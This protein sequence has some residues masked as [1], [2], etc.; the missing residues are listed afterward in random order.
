MHRGYIVEM[1]VSTKASSSTSELLGGRKKKEVL[2]SRPV[3]LRMFAR[4]SSTSGDL[5]MDP[6]LSNATTSFVLYPDLLNMLLILLMS[7]FNWLS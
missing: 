4:R 1:M 6:S 5:M 3:A 2:E 7:V